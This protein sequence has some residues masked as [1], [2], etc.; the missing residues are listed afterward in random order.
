MAQLLEKYQIP[1]EKVELE[2]TES[3]ILEDIDNSRL[4]LNQL[5]SLGLNLAIDDFGTGYSS[6][7]YLQKFPFDK[8]KIDKS[9]IDGLPSNK[10]NSVIVNSII[11]LCKNFNLLVLAEGVEHT[12]QEQFLL[13]NGCNEGQGYLYEKP[14][15]SEQ[16]LELIK[17][18]NR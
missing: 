12:E 8:I 17:N 5:K 15:S 7:S 3:Y 14:I 9:F 6:L 10:E 16:I 18:Y 11:Q 1:S 13:E 2:V 4:R